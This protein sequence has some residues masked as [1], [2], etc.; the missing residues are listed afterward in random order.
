[1]KKTKLSQ[2]NKSAATPSDFPW[3]P[4]I[5][6]AASFVLV[7]IVYGPALNGPF[8][9]DDRFQ[10]FL[11]PERATIPFL[12]WIRSS[13]PLLLSTFWLNYQAGGTAPFGYHAVNILLHFAA[14]AAVGF[15]LAKL[16]DLSGLP[17]VKSTGFALFGA[18]LFLLHPLQTESVSYVIS[19][20]EP[21]SILLYFSAFAL[22]LY[23]PEGPI[24]WGR[25]AA[26]ALLF[27]AGLSTK[28]HT[29]TLPALLLLTDFYFRPGEFRKRLRIYALLA[30][31]AAGGLVWVASTLR[32][33]NSAGL[34]LESLTPATYAFTQGRMIWNYVRLF[35]LPV[36]QNLDPDIPV[37]HSLMDHGAI[38]AWAALLAA[39]GVAWLYRKTWP[40]ASYGFLVFLLLLAPTS[41]II[42]ILDVF[43]EHR[44]YLPFIGLAL[45]A[46]DI[47]RRVKA[48][49]ATWVCIAILAVCSVLTFQRNQ[50][51]GDPI[52]LWTD[53]VSK[54]PR[55]AR[56]NF[57]LAHAYFEKQ[58][59]AKALPY[60]EAAG[61]VDKRNIRMLI[62][63]AMTY[64]CLGR[65]EE[66]LAKLQQADAL[67]PSASTKASMA[68]FYGGLR[69]WPDVLRVLD[70]AEKQDPNY[71]YT[72]T[73]RGDYFEVQGDY[74]AAAEQH[75]KALSIAPWLQKARD[76]LDRVTRRSQ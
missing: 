28:E 1:M 31:V 71:A 39:V 49:Q 69:R 32:Q 37:S 4:V 21:L 22:Y 26:I 68:I 33:S 44:L 19:R 70:E 54:S 13:R 17:R 20:S 51:W 62:D 36:G 64:E 56:P 3:W 72:Y 55:K 59:C 47:L 67:V 73:Y 74:A 35:F 10:V 53:A 11:N 40:L 29:I 9:F 27:V 15:S 48:S 38:F 42:P 25:A 75:R 65:Y 24:G 41:S 5:A 45:V 34:N 16:L 61:D 58:Q 60:F 14:S 50:L 2:P 63:W 43:A 66:G 46:I 23:R 76:S 12:Q 8:V 30:V 18:A 52:L 57:Q 7:W 6:A